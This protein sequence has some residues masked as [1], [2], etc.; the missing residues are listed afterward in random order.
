MKVI[1]CIPSYSDSL[2]TGTDNSL[3]RTRALLDA[4][5][6][7]HDTLRHTRNQFISVARNQL[8]HE[9][10]KTDGTDLFFIDDDVS[11]PAK[12]VV[13]ILLRPEAIVAGVY[14]MKVD[15]EDYPVSLK[16]DEN[17]TPMGA[18]GLIEAAGLPAG[19]LR[20]KREAFTFLISKYPELEYTD[21]L[22]KETY[23]DLF[24]CGLF[25]KKWWGEDYSFC[26][27]VVQAGGRIWVMPDIDFSHRGTKEWHG[28]LHNWLCKLSNKS[29]EETNALLP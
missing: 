6:I 16:T 27:R 18:N 12:A 17:G 10:M 20:I 7:E 11:F 23:Y 9:F 26:R 13:D 1:F 22:T 4:I 21:M 8:V 15:S 29:K 14:P 2:S 28:N 3:I 5:P 25:D 19:F 24:G